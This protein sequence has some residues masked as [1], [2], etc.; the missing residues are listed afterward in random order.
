MDLSNICLI[1]KKLLSYSYIKIKSFIDVLLI[2]I[3][4]NV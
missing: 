4:I 2:A 3:C 1:I